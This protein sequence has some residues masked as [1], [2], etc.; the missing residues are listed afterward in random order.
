MCFAIPCMW[1]VGQ[2]DSFVFQF[3]Y[4]AY[5]DFN[6]RNLKLRSQ[7][8]NWTDLNKQTQ[9]HQVLNSAR[10]RD[11]LGLL[12]TAWLATD[13]AANNRPLS[14]EHVHCNGIVHNALREL[15]FSSVHELWMRLNFQRDAG[16]QSV[17]AAVDA[18]CVITRFLQ[19]ASATAQVMRGVRCWSYDTIRDAILTVV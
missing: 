18:H 3:N 5:T 2:D 8:M 7:R 1:Y 19:D 4:I 12:H 9:L 11:D 16:R 15:C 10:Q 14:S 17:I 13:T 6:K